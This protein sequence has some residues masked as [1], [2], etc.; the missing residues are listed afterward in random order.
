MLKRILVMV[1]LMVLLTACDAPIEHTTQSTCEPSLPTTKLETVPVDLPVD[2]KIE[3]FSSSTRVGLWK[4]LMLDD[5]VKMGS[6]DYIYKLL[7]DDYL[8][9]EVIT[10]YEATYSNFF[11]FSG[12]STCERVDISTHLGCACKSPEDVR[13]DKYNLHAKLYITYFYYADGSC[14]ELLAGEPYEQVE[15]YANVYKYSRYDGAS[16]CYLVLQSPNYACRYDI[17]TAYEDYDCVAEELF[18]Y[19]LGLSV[20]TNT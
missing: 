18:Q 17:D 9:E 4:W 11:N 14:R 3:G 6:N 8:N 13:L 12:G 1:L 16:I 10:V 19:V 2:P 5:S 7:I 20:P 15:G